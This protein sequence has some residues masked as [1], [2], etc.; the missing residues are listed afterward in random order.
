VIVWQKSH[1]TPKESLQVCMVGIS[2]SAGKSFRTLMFLKAL[3]AGPVGWGANWALLLVSPAAQIKET[4][5]IAAKS[6]AMVWRTW[7]GFFTQNLLS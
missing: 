2:F 6:I 4:G 7:I 5:A 3:P 1:F